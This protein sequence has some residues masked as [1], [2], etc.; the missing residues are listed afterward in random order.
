MLLG[1]DLDDIRLTLE[2]EAIRGAVHGKLLRD[3]ETA[4]KNF[5]APEKC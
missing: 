2:R 4:V 1:W 3:P 5:I